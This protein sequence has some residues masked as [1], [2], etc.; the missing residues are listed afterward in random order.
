MTKHTTPANGT[1]KDTGA[2]SPCENT[3]ETNLAGTA[4]T[5]RA[6]S[7]YGTEQG[8]LTTRRDLTF[9]SG[10]EKFNHLLPEWLSTKVAKSP[11]AGSGVH[12]WLF[13]MA[14]QLHGY[15]TA[16]EIEKL[17]ASSVSRCGRSVDSR[18]IRDA[19]DA[20]SKVKK[21]GR[22][23]RY[24][25][26]S[27]HNTTISLRSKTP[28]W[29]AVNSYRQKCVISGM[30]MTEVALSVGSPL[31]IEGDAPPMKWFLERL[32]SP[33]SLL[34]IAKSSREF[35]TRSLQDLLCLNLSTA[36]LIVPSPMSATH[37][38]T[39]TG[40]RSMHSLDNTGARRYIVSE[41]DS[42]THDEQAALI[43]HL[44]DYANLVMVLRSGGKSLH[45]WWA[46]AGV[47]EGKVLRFFRYAV[48]LGADPAT[49]TRSQFVRI[50][51]GWRAEKQVRQQV[52][53]FDSS[54]L[55]VEGGAA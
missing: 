43:W 49:W 54:N 33:D 20:S 48:S 21:A 39:K 37:G 14:L 46:C 22:L 50:P 40:K 2:V 24:D 34:C 12:Q 6:T 10:S 30:P 47:D 15:L 51:Q 55:P 3:N 28:K 9:A 4:P 42:G 53:Y 52:L 32:F 31:L 7:Y 19:V 11:K 1:K 13:T 18:E 44:R 17:L 8:N 25:E 27:T 41:F 36:E 16:D 5:A 45:A 23:G 35:S 26:K 38:V 29:P